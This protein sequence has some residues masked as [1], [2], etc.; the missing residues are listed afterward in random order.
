RIYVAPVL[1]DYLWRDR[2]I[3]LFE[4]RVRREPRDQ[5]VIKLLA[6]QYM[7]RYRENQDPGDILR[8]A[9]RARRTIAL[10]PQNNASGFEILASAYTALHRFRVARAFEARAQRANPADSNPPAQMASLDMELGDYAGAKRDLATAARIRITPTVL[11]V[12]ARYLELTGHLTQARVL[13]RRAMEQS[14]SIADNS[15]QS[16]AWYHFRAGELAFSVGDIAEAKQDERDALTAFPGFEMAYRALARFCWATKDWNCALNTASKGAQIVPEPEILGYQA[17]A[18]DALGK[19]ADAAQTR[20]LIVALER[21]G[22][23]YRLNDRLLAVYFAEHGTHRS[24]ALRI[25]QREVRVRGNEIYAQDTLAWA[26]AMAGRWTIASQAARRAVRFDTDDS[27]IQ[28]HAGL[29]ALHFNR[30]N[31]A[32]RRLQKALSLNPRFDPFYADKAR[33]TLASLR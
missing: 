5:V 33:E 32:R 13:L 9:D 23:A 28:F 15:A 27:R 31:E 2:T 1:P 3:A 8:A 10:Q 19:R 21:I 7:Q 18:Q 30:R 29:I 17:D 25:A 4:E 26:A 16:R 14:D 22:N 12:R 20:A 11:S 24:D 6:A